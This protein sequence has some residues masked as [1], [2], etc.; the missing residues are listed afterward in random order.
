MVT[1]EGADGIHDLIHFEE[2]LTV[3]CRVEVVEVLADNVII[4][5]V[6]LG[7]NIAQYFQ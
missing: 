2:C 5:A 6:E 7:E 1:A 3:H 4:E